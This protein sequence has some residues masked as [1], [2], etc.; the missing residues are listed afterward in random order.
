LKN[1]NRVG[2]WDKWDNAKPFVFNTGLPDLVPA[3][4]KNGTKRLGG[5]RFLRKAVWK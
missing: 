2:Q 1:K 4:D 5:R 3:W